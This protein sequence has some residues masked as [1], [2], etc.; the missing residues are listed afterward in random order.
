VTESGR[1]GR[2]AREAEKDPRT[3]VMK[4]SGEGG[5]QGRPT[6]LLRRAEH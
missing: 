6:L 2:S 3:H 1:Q 5:S 4:G